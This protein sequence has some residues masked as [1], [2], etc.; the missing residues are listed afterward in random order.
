MRRRRITRD[1]E[2]NSRSFTIGTLY[3]T[4]KN[5][6][7]LPTRK[8]QT[9]TTNHRTQYT[10]TMWESHSRQPNLRKYTLNASVRARANERSNRNCNW[11][12]IVCNSDF[13]RRLDGCLGFRLGIVCYWNFLSSHTLVCECVCVFFC[14]YYGYTENSFYMIVIKRGSE[15]AYLRNRKAIGSMYNFSFLVIFYFADAHI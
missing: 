14:V 9:M 11:E 4:L 3:C 8:Q 6:A 7:H 5:T 1:K 10:Y 12:G 13:E 15:F 2:T